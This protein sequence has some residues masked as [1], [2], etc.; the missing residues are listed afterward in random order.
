MFGIT[1]FLL[2]LIVIGIG[3]Q[4]PDF[5]VSLRAVLQGHQDVAFAD[6]LGSLIVKSLLFFGVFALIKP[7]VVDP[8]LLIVSMI[9]S[10]MALAL[11]LYFAKKEILTWKG[12]IVLIILYGTFICIELITKWLLK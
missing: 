1:P 5:A 6:I 12:G 2:S 8:G 9:F 7:L 11:T 3:A 4:V 10:A